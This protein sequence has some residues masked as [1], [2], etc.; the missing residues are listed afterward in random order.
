MHVWR[1][2]ERRP[3]ATPCGGHT[4]RRRYIYSFFCAMYFFLTNC[5]CGA[6]RSGASS[7]PWHERLPGA[8]RPSRVRL[9]RARRFTHRRAVCRPSCVSLPPDRQPL[10]RQQSPSDLH[11]PP[12]RLK[13]VSQ[14]ARSQQYQLR[15]ACVS[16]TTAPEFPQSS[17]SGHPA[18]WFRSV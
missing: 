11:I 3:R 2:S 8:A 15:Y 14:R 7:G 6:I 1:V 10:V 17:A 4:L 9:V 18:G 5:R 16:F 12:Q 13:Q